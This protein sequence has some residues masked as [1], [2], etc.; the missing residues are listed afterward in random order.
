M[1]E[2][3]SLRKCC[4]WCVLCTQ[5]WEMVLLPSWLFFPWHWKQSV[6]HCCME[7][8]DVITTAVFWQCSVDCA[9]S[10]T[11]TGSNCRPR[12]S[13]SRHCGW[14]GCHLQRECEENPV[15]QIQRN[16][17]KIVMTLMMR[18]AEPCSTASL[19]S[20][21]MFRLCAGG[22]FLFHFL[23]FC[24]GALPFYFHEPRS[25]WVVDRMTTK[26]VYV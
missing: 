25:F 24:W 19:F 17:L 8:V 14:R 6:L 7:R 20:A 26:I 2:R 11:A 22:L 1:N 23:L 9:V 21:A 16:W 18:W 5:C 10:D 13:W 12:C 15:C 4:C 3:L